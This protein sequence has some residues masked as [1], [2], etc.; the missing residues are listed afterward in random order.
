[1]SILQSKGA[2]LLEKLCV[3]EFAKSRS[4]HSSDNVL[5]KLING[6]VVH[7]QTSRLYSFG[8]LL[9]EKTI[10]AFCTGFLYL[11]TQFLSF[12]LF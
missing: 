8:G 10:A 1:M 7:K 2:K 9:N 6:V 3:I 4:K 11:H 12:L 5:V